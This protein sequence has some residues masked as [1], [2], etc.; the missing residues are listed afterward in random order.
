MFARGGGQGLGRAGEQQPGER[1]ERG[2]EGQREREEEA[3]C[4]SCT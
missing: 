2:I 4:R 3:L 1:G